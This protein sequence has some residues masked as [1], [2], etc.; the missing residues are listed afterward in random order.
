MGDV[1]GC[2]NTGLV[3]SISLSD[4]KSWR[5][6]WFI[7]LDVDWAHDEVF[8][9]AIDLVEEAG[10]CATWLITHESGCLERLTS[11]PLFEVGIHP[12]FNGLLSGEAAGL[13][14]PPR[15]IISDLLRFVPEARVVRSHSLAYSSRLSDIFLESGL[16]HDLNSYIPSDAAKF[17]S[18]WKLPN[19][20]IRVPSRWED[21]LEFP[22]KA[23][24]DWSRWGGVRVLNFHP[25]HLFLNTESLR[26][27]EKTR[28][29]HRSPKDLLRSRNDGLGTE[30]VFASLVS[31]LFE[32][33]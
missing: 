3:G 8:G 7:T 25:I 19:G 11:N 21:D 33:N 13:Q 30:S 28:V 23:V 5:D 18:P 1:L 6:K 26:R 32:L 15:E 10:I 17:I 29:F 20:Q 31:S 9:H 4:P 16:T 22:I 2:G 24:P 12:N 14:A 27:Y